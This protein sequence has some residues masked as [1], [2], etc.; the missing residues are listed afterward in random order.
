MAATM[1][2]KKRR[3]YKTWVV[4]RRAGGNSA[5]PFLHL[6]RNERPR[7]RG[8]EQTGGP[9]PPGATFT[10]LGDLFRQI[11]RQLTTA[12]TWQVYVLVVQVAT[13]LKQRGSA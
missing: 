5:C 11:G 2:N 3:A 10:I 1:P 4:Y 8:P 12:R 6:T 13:N 9:C 7:C